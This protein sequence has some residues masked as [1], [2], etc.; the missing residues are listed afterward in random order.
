[1]GGGGGRAV[2]GCAQVSAYSLRKRPFSSV[3]TKLRTHK[4]VTGHDDTRLATTLR[5]RWRILREEKRIYSCY[6]RTCRGVLW[7]WVCVCVCAFVC[8]DMPGSRTLGA[9]GAGYFCDRT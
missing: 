5:V 9:K 7:V 1:M 6:R 8:K 4:S 2:F 3:E